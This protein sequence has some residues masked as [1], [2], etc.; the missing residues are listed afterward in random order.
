MEIQSTEYKRCT[1][2]KASGRID[3][4]NAPELGAALKQLNANGI[5]NL[6]FDMP[7]IK[8]MASAGWWVLID[9]QKACKPK[10]GELVLA[11]VDKGIR[12][13]LKLV[14]M[15][16]YFKIYDDLTSAVGSF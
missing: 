7:E 9:I 12:E 1:V 6:V 14:G 4:S 2:I 5:F 11:G 3:G 16:T 15:D 10:G 8:F 13:S